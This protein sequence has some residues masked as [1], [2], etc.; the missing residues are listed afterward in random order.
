MLGGVLTDLLG[1]H[2]AMIIGAALTLMGAVITLIFLPE[3]R[4][5]KQ[6]PDDAAMG[7]Q[8]PL[9]SIPSEKA[10]FFSITALFSTNRLVIAGILMSTLG[11]FLKNQFGEQVQVAGYSFGVTTLTGLGLGL[12]TLIAMVSAPLIGVVSDRVGNRWWVAAGGLVQIGRA[13]CRERV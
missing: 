8:R 4:S 10:E 6:Y 12:S 3:T 2:Q 5:S 1:F 13:S 11:I 7:L 9:A